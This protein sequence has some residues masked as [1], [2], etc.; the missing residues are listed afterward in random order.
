M[1]QKTRSV[2][3]RGIFNNELIWGGGKIQLSD[4]TADTVA[5][6]SAAAWKL[7]G[8]NFAL[9]LKFSPL[10]LNATFLEP[11]TLVS[12]QSNKQ[13]MEEHTAMKADY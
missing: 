1:C 7:R 10:T 9:I 12:L 13:G 6:G 3:L 11:S 8:H 5:L 2:S 4:R